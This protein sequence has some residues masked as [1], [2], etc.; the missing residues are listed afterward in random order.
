MLN[1]M[2][3]IHC[4]QLNMLCCG[5]GQSPSAESPALLLLLSMNCTS[6]R[7]SPGPGCKPV[8]LGIAQPCPCRPML[9]Q[10]LCIRKAFSKLAG[11]VSVQA[12]QMLLET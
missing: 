4:T 1:M 12:A 11:G 2:Q 5:I 9:Q 10:W 7:Y 3:A 8:Q 6:L